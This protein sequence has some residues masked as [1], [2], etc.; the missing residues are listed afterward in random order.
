[1]TLQR[2]PARRITVIVSETD[3]WEHRPLA[4]EILHR[5][6][7]AGLPGASVFRG[8]EG[9]GT[10][11]HIHT[12]RIL[13]LSDELPIAVVIV[14]DRDAIDDFVPEIA[15]LLKRGGVLTIED[16]EVVE[17][18]RDHLAEPGVPG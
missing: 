6:H 13:S 18:V 9:Y 14:G 8:V 11:G 5:A 12:V 1:M 3:T 10:T 4:T 16:V 2:R 7:A 17:M 15:P